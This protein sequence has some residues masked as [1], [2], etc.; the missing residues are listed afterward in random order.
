MSNKVLYKKEI[1]HNEY[2]LCFVFQIIFEHFVLKILWNSHHSFWIDA[3]LWPL[4]QF[5]PNLVLF[6]YMCEQS[7]R[8]FS[9]QIFWDGMGIFGSV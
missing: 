6:I 5:E 3:S 1:I 4:N 8:T 9:T 7:W 2:F